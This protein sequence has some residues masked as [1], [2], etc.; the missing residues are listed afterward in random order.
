MAINWSSG[1]SEKCT[2]ITF[3]VSS[4]HNG[5]QIAITIVFLLIWIQLA[6][7]QQEKFQILCHNS[8]FLIL[9]NVKIANLVKL[10]ENA[11]YFKLALRK[12]NKLLQCYI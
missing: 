6:I 10:D 4:L 11:L 7:G 12:T 3:Q 2:K 5:H 1:W 9:K 8:S